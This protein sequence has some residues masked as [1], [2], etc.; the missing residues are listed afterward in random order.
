MH[1]RKKWLC[2]KV[3]LNNGITEVEFVRD[4]DGQEERWHGNVIVEPNEYEK[5]KYYWW[6]GEPAFPQR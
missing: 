2:V 6:R 1:E 5:G 4:V 3:R